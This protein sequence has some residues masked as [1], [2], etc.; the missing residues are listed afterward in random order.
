[1][2]SGG[3]AMLPLLRRCGYGLLMLGWLVAGVPRA[4]GSTIAYYRFE[5]GLP[6]TTGGT[7]VDSSGNHL[8]G[9]ANGP[10]YRTDVPTATVR[11]Q[12]NTRS[13]EVNGRPGNVVSVPDHRLFYLT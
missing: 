5:E 9:H 12:P 7:V 10:I 1:P 11:G 6:G 13:M 3:T 2:A 4:A 8:D